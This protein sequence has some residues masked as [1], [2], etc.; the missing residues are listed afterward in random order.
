M[1][2]TQPL[3]YADGPL[4]LI[5]HLAR[6]DAQA[7]PRPGV[8]VVHEFY[9]LGDHAKSRADRLAAEL[10]YVALAV[11][12]YGHG[13]LVATPQEAMAVMG[14]IANDPDVLRRRMRAGLDTLRAQPG[15]DPGRVAAIGFCFGGRCCLELARDGGDVR[16][17]V[18]F[19]GGLETARPAAQG[20][21]TAKVLSCTG[22]ADPMIAE[23]KVTAFQHEMTAA[24][25]DWQTVVYGGAEHAFTNPAAGRAG[26][27]GLKYD[28]AADRRSWAA[29]CDLFAEVFGPG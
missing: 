18:S 14:P 15:V 29:M 16:A 10:G 4:P 8:L 5:G 3:T 6:D 20:G 1:L 11:D 9:G 21:I 7:G 12:M 27:P 22:S 13:K 17:V 28:A 25:A 2:Q 19:H 24:G 23:G 26:V